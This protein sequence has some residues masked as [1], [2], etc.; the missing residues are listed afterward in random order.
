M[1]NTLSG[2]IKLVA[3]ATLG[4]AAITTLRALAQTATPTPTPDEIDNFILTIGRDQGNYHAL[5]KG[6]SPE[7]FV[8]L[9]CHDTTR[10]YDQ[11]KK[12]HLKTDHKDCRFLPKDCDQCKPPFSQLEIKTDKVIASE[13]AKR[14]QVGEETP[15]GDPH[16][17]TQI[18]SLSADDI[19]AVLDKLA[20]Q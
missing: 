6:V 15:I 2:T 13:T 12:L 3:V 10:Q 1:K 5:R 19:K 18:A 20:T 7:D 8:N 16:V 14:I 4:I 11:S 9:V 17:T